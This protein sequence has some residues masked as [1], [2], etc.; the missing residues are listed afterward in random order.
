MNFDVIIPSRWDLLNL[1][2]LLRSIVWQNF[3]P[4]KIYIII[5]KVLNKSELEEIKYFLWKWDLNSISNIVEII[6]NLTHEFL[7]WKWVSALRNYWI[8]VS[9]SDFIYFLDD[10]NVFDSDFFSISNKI[11]LQIN[12]NIKKDFIL[13][14]IIQYRT[15]DIVQSRGI[16]KFSF[17]LSRVVL[18]TDDISLYNKVDMIGWNSLF[19][20]SYIFKKILFDNRFEFIYEDL[21][22]SYRCTLAGYPIMVSNQFRINHME[23]DKSKIEKSFI[24]DPKSAYQKSR[25]R[26]WFVRKN[27]NYYQKFLFF[28]FWLNIQTVWFMFLIII[29]WKHKISLTKAMFNWIYDGF[30]W[31]L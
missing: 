27:A 12:S 28:V 22:F 10:D 3:C 2:K 24:W 17:F 20:P 5:D 8:S 14:P 18:N 6:T 9:K 4:T 13:S 15:T 19:W 7:P 23:R 26:I 21:D 30:F 1:E 29:Y 16:R 25:N 11:R 31:E